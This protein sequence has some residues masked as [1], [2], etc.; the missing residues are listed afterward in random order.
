MQ[1]RGRKDIRYI[2]DKT[3]LNIAKC[4]DNSVCKRPCK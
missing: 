2:K 3:E 4:F 1:H